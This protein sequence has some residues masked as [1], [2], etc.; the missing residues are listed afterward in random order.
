LFRAVF[1]RSVA[2]AIKAYA[3]DSPLDSNVIGGEL[4]PQLIDRQVREH[5]LD[6]TDEAFLRVT[7]RARTGNEHYACLHAAPLCIEVLQAADADILLRG[8]FHYGKKQSFYGIAVH[9][10]QRGAEAA[11]GA[12]WCHGGTDEAH[13]FLIGVELAVQRTVLRRERAHSQPLRFH[14]KDAH[15]VAPK[16]P[17]RAECELAIESG[18]SLAD[19][20]VRLQCLR[21]RYYHGEVHV[22]RGGWQL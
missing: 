11:G 13:R 10:R 17:G 3:D 20:A 9:A 2:P 19:F 15:D 1:R 14:W 6:Q 18:Q 16:L 22:G 5:L 7:L 21:R 12:L 4:H 8:L